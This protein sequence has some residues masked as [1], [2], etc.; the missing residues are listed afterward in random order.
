[1]VDPIW[2]I[3]RGAEGRAKLAL[4]RSFWFLHETFINTC[5]MHL[6]PVHTQTHAPDIRG[7]ER[8]RNNKNKKLKLNF[9]FWRSTNWKISN[10]MIYRHFVYLVPCSFS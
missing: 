5:Y 8:K 1:M 4:V 9:L 10:E 3:H 7:R 6:Y 2:V